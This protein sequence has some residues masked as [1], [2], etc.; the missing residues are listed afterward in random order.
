MRDGSRI[1]VCAVDEPLH[2][3][4]RFAEVHRHG[5]A[6]DGYPDA[7]GDHGGVEPVVVQQGLAFVDAVGPVRYHRSDLPLG[8]VHDLSDIGREALD[9]VLFQQCLDAPCRYLHRANLGVQV[10]EK[11][12]GQPDVRRHH[13]Q[14]VSARHALVVNP[15][16][17]DAQ[18][19]LVYLPG[20][21]VV[22][23]VSPSADVGMMGPVDRIEEDLSVVEQGLYYGNVGKVASTEVGVVDHEHVAVRDIFSE[24]VADR[25][26]R[27]W[28]RADV[29]GKPLSLGHE[30][31]VGIQDRRGKVSAGVEYLRHGRA[32][33]HLHHLLGHRLQA[34]LQHREGDGVDARLGLPRARCLLPRFLQRYR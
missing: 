23:A 32:Q 31:T 30:L 11:I 15:Q 25:R 9:A 7:N 27:D 33:H 6:V 1:C 3:R 14:Q 26:H 2:L 4:T 20:V 34:M 17:R 28:Q 21:R 19:L 12:D 24:V 16:R 8:R 22:S 10:A 29:D 18:A 5:V 13:M